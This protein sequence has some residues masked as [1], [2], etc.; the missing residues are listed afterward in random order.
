VLLDQV[1]SVPKIGN[2]RTLDYSRLPRRCVVAIVSNRSQTLKLV[3]ERWAAHTTRRNGSRPRALRLCW[4][5]QFCTR[6][7]E[8]S[9]RVRWRLSMRVRQSRVF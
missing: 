3:N 9:L 2:T 7:V 6:V 4:I 1:S 8:S 5:P